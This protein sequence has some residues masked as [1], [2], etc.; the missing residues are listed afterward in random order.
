MNILY[1]HRTQGK[2]GEGVHIR[3]IIKALERLGHKVFIVSP[4]GV[5]VFKEDASTA[6]AIYKQSRFSRLWSWISR[7]TPQIVFELL[8]IAYNFVAGQ[9]IEKILAENNIDLIYERYSFFTWVGGSKAKKHKIPLILEVNEVS[10]IKRQRG[11]VLVGLANKIENDL[12]KKV[13]AII[14]VSSF[15]KDFIVKKGLPA[16]K[17]NVISNAVDITRFD[18]NIS[19][20]DVRNN[21][22]L[23]GKTVLGFTG[24]FSRWDKLDEL[25][26]AFSDIALQRPETH[27]MLVGDAPRLSERQQLEKLIDHKKLRNRVSITGKV[28]RADVVRYISAIDLC[29]IPSSN[30]FGS[31]LVLFEYMGMGKAVIAPNIAPIEDVITNNINGV[32]FELN[33]PESMKRSIIYLIDDAKKREEIGSAARTAVQEKHQWSHNA[34]RVIDIYNR[35]S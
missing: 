28:S 9:K 20:E 29:L 13:D 6:I 5:D 3:E 33:D 1:H 16:A 32:L 21:L 23:I 14:V 26:K 11:Q 27:L 2:G 4:P 22:G 35:M 19:G 30:P 25:I 8:E 24:H 17:I 15:L 7:N 31:P 12:F 18:S 34:K 10:G